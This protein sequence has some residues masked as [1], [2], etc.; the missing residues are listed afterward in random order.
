M[1]HLA[2]ALADSH[3]VPDHDNGAI[4]LIPRDRV[5]LLTHAAQQLQEVRD[6]TLLHPDT[7]EFSQQVQMVSA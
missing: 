5:C 4:I 7:K 6:V 2:E 3:P 1:P